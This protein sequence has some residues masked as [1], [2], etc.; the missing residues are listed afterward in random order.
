MKRLLA[1]I[2]LTVA[3]LPAAAQDYVAFE[4]IDGIREGS[5]KTKM[6]THTSRLLTA[7]NTAERTGGSINFKD[8]DIDE[9]ASHSIAMLW[10]NVHFRTFDD[11]IISHCLTLSRNGSVKGYQVR[12]I[13]ID[14]KPFDDT[15]TDSK[16]QE[17]CI[18][19]DEK[20]RIVDF[21]LTIGTNQYKRIMRE[22]LEL[23]DLER[24]QEIIDYVQQ[25]RNAYNKKNLAFM[26][27]IFSDD[28]L[29]ITGKVIRRVPNEGVYVKPEIRY[30]KQSK[31]QYLANLKSCFARQSY[32]N[33]V[34]DDIKV[35]RSGYNRNFYGV[36]LIQRWNSSTYSDE[37]ILFLVWNFENPDEPK[38]NVRT[39]QPMETDKDDI[40]SLDKIKY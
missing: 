37:G 24:R 26:E 34:F 10:D 15:Y 40:F 6:E 39:W 22:G 28:A 33:V 30:S 2:L 36:T 25:F 20:G 17:I 16:V 12:D 5:L 18:D 9:M 3:V 8:I 4:L 11:D 29:I 21:N 38:I 14:M 7:I 32:I 27:D 1:M 19:Y 31:Q 13:E 35:V 23:E